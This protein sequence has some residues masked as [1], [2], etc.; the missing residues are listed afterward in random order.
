MKDLADAVA[1]ASELAGAE[2]RRWYTAKNFEA[3]LKADAS[4]VTSADLASHELLCKSLIA[5]TPGVPV[6]SE[7]SGASE[8]EML[9]EI[10]GAPEYWLVDPLDGTRDFLARTG[11]FCTC[12][13]LVRDAK[14]V[15]GVI[16][17]PAT[18]RT[19]VGYA[20]SRTLKTR[21]SHPSPVF[22]ISRQHPGG[23]EA[24]IRKAL[25][26]AVTEK[27]GSALKY[28]RI[29][30]GEADA[31]VRFTPTSLWDIAAGEALLA[32]AGGGMRSLAG[33]ALD[34]SGKSLTHPPFVAA[35]DSAMLDR[36][37]DQLVH[38]LD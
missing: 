10:R 24:R 2:I 5:L 26:A 38:A 22:L 8:Q 19:Y 33:G 1:R 29:A 13:A 12:V 21:K 25:P 9:G 37:A 18:G 27:L 28:A 7:E 35:G 11:E 15:L 31:S 23:E 3:K 32:F 17:E 6:I 36:I 16:H 30:S 34:Y 20:G 4:P 14:P